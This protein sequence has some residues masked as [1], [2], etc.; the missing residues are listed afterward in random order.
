[1][2]VS[3]QAPETLWETA[4]NAQQIVSWLGCS[5]GVDRT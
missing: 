5:V 3:A 1:M 4:L 2:E